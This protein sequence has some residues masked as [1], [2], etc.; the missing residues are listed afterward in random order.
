MNEIEYVTRAEAEQL[1]AQVAALQSA[2]IDVTTGLIHLTGLVEGLSL[3][4][5]SNPNV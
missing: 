2:L 5:D 1:G 3:R 4:K